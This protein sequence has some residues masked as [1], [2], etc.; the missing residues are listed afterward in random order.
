MA[1]A[2]K[3]RP[4]GRSMRET[5]DV[6]NFT[7]MELWKSPTGQSIAD[8]SK[9]VKSMVKVAMSGQMAASTTEDSKPGSSVVRVNWSDQM[10]ASTRASSEA[11]FSTASE[12]TSFWT[13]GS[14][15]AIGTRI[16]GKVSAFF[17]T[18]T[19]LFFSVSGKTGTW[20]A[21][22]MKSSS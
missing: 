21:K 13:N 8:N 19:V 9:T 15:K 6:V 16:R 7:E 10:A 12:P 22:W 4:M 20:T 3:S 5:S 1:K 18:M 2:N 14:M 17:G 11:D